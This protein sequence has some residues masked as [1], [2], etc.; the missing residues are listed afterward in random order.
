MQ[1]RVEKIEN[2]RAELKIEIDAEQVDKA[3]DRAYRKIVKE[4]N[5]PGFR[6]GKAPRRIVETQV[7]TE[8]IFKEALDFML[9]DAYS[10]AIEITG[11]KPISQPDVEID[12]FEEGQDL[13]I[14][15]SVDVRPEVKLGN[16][17]GLEISKPEINVSDAAVE[18]QLKIFQDRYAKLITITEGSIENGDIALIDYKGYIDGQTFAGGIEDNYPLEVG[19]GSFI[20]G[21]EEQLVGAKPG[22]TIDV[23]VNFPEDYR[24]STLAGKPAVFNVI[25][26][27]I[28]RK[29]I[30][31]LDDE[32][33]KDVSEFDTLEE[34]KVDIRKKLTERMAKQ[35][36][37]DMRDEIIKK[38]VDDSQVDTPELMVQRRIDAHMSRLSDRLQDDGYSVEDYCR[39]ADTTEVEIRE[40]YYE[41]AVQS[42]KTDLVLEEIA[43]VENIKVE[44]EEILEEIQEL[45]QEYN[46]DMEA[47]EKTLQS[48]DS[49]E[50]LAYGIMIDKTIKLLVDNSTQGEAA[51]SEAAEDDPAESE[52]TETDSE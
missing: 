12:Q 14:S 2:N 23:E 46:E 47:L 7:G 36:V 5:I 45:A 52:A 22:D 27:E 40:K 33:A 35:A 48:R 4:I 17:K 8:P 37:K 26:K 24:E 34:L 50:A 16:Y 51:E 39:V 10:E 41:Q 31:P 11:I 1:A 3:L 25:V 44:E 9:P 42:V 29:E 20:Q 49:I 21:F 30:A 6:I 15:I 32:F 38:V 18:E 19:S 43:E 13:L 28:K